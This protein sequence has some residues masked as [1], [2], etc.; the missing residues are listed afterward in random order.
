MRYSF[1]YLFTIFFIVLFQS[2]TAQVSWSVEGPG[3]G[4]WLTAIT[5][6][7]DPGHTAYVA[8][9]VGGIY[10]STDL[11]ANWVIKDEGLSNYFTHDIAYDP[12]DPDILY[13]ATRGGVFKSVDGAEHWEAKRDNFPD[14]NDYEYSAPISDIV[15]DPS[16]PSTIYAGVGVPESGYNGNHWEDVPVKGSIY[17][18]TNK[19]ENWTLIY[20]TGIDTSAMIYSL[21]IDSSNS[22]V[23][24]AATDKG[25]YK[26]TTAG[27]TWSSFSAGLPHLLTMRLAIDP[28]NTG[29]LYVTLWATPGE[30][31][32]KGG[33]YKSVDGGDWQAINTNLPHEIGAVS[34]MTCNYP[35]LVI[36]ENDPLTL[37]VGNIPWTPNPG[38]YKTINGGVS[39]DWVSDPETNMSIGWIEEAE[40]SAMCL[41]IDPIDS[42]SLYFGTSMHLFKTEHAGADWEQVYTNDV[43][44]GY[45]KGNGFET[46]CA[47]AIA[48]DPK[49]SNKVYV[50]YWDTGFF[51]SL[52][53]GNSFKNCSEG[54]NYSANTFDIIID[55]D[56]SQ[57]IYAACGWW[58]DN[59]GEVYKSIDS[60]ENWVAL[61]NSIIDAQIWSIALDKNTPTNARILYAT[62][63]DNGVYKS[64]NGGTSWFLINNGLGVENDGIRNL[65]VR[66]VYIDPN[67]SDI[68]YAGIEAKHVDIGAVTKTIHG[69]LFKSIDQGANWVRVDMSMPQL[70]I[71]DIDVDPNNSQII[72]TSVSSEYDHTEGNEY[73][74]GVYKSPDGGVSW[75]AINSGFGIPDNLDISS[76]AISPTDSSIL[77]ATTT[78]APYHDISNG[79]GI[80]KSN[81]AGASWLPIN[82]GLGVLYYSL[83]SIDSKNPNVLYAASAGNGLLKGFDADIVGIED[84]QQETNLITINNFPNPFKE[85]TQISFDLKDDENV[86]LNIYNIQGQLVKNLL[87]NKSY[88]AGRHNI[89]W[90]GRGVNNNRVSTGLYFYSLKTSKHSVVGKMLVE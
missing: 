58:E 86:E 4:G 79:R 78:D 42:N 66:K 33:V 36:D 63:Y 48:V 88:K 83:I 8:C 76:L 14:I 69:G 22:D 81:N 52:D 62:S 7:N 9:D 12:S 41:A 56:D 46:T 55:P 37:Y 3:G 24:Y 6:V 44:G 90:N 82:E 57:I 59:L 54:M 43:G 34:G 10:K 51:K 87:K 39:W 20:N 45:W 65:Q 38:I 60:G 1:T 47:S 50:G 21:A 35:T 89:I 27:A 49:D 61:N 53:G 13:I 77:Y 75:S 18:S 70:S 67:N 17:K 28:V 30:S 73:F 84:Y 15:V 11:G 32:W 31:E 40:V 16:N 23:L 2:L 85:T 25:V 74:G 80:F 71:W 68:L 19:A 29:T 26:S 64:I 72:Y 5:V